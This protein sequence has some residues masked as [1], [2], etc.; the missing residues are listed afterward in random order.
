MFG[1]PANLQLKNYNRKLNWNVKRTKFNKIQTYVYTR[2]FQI[3]GILETWLA[4]HIPSASILNEFIIFRNDRNINGGG[5]LLALSPLLDPI[6]LTSHHS[7]P[8][9]SSQSIWASIN[10]ANKRWL[11]GV[12]YR[13]KP[14]DM[15][16]LDCME[17]TLTNLHL[18][19]FAGTCFLVT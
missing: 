14:M 1:P 6:E 5:M 12:F 4:S 16:A 7:F 2:N 8:N 3:V 9:T 15:E 10:I 18:E 17:E 19:R 13:P 11:C